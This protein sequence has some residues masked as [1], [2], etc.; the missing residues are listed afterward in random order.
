MTFISGE[1]LF[2]RLDEM[3]SGA[4]K[5]PTYQISGGDTRGSLNDLEPP[6]CLDKSIAV[7]ATAIRRD[8]IAMDY[9][10]AT[11]MAD[12]VQLRDVGRM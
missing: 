11:E 8:I 2:Q 4:E 12:K 6:S 7:F 3:R 5:H 9:V 1:D 10:F